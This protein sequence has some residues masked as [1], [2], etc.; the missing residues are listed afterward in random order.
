MCERQLVVIIIIFFVIV[1]FFVVALFFI[2][3]IDIMV[4]ILLWATAQ[5]SRYGMISYDAGDS[6]QESASTT[7]NTQA[8]L[9]IFMKGWGR[10]VR[11]LTQSRLSRL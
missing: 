7:T 9:C 11:S 5:A 6:K 3:V 8:K 2:V 10:T 1:L 4:F